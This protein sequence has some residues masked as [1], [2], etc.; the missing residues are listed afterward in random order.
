MNIG[1]VAAKDIT[2]TVVIDKVLYPARI[3]RRYYSC[4]NKQLYELNSEVI[5]LGYPYI[6]SKETV[7]SITCIYEDDPDENGDYIKHLKSIKVGETD[8]QVTYENNSNDY[9]AAL[10]SPVIT[11]DF[12]I[13]H[14][15][16]E[17]VKIMEQ[18]N[19]NHFQG[20]E[21]PI[22]CNDFDHLIPHG[23]RYWFLCSKCFRPL[24]Y[25]MT[26]Y[27][28]NDEKLDNCI[29][30][31]HSVFAFYMGE[32][33]AICGENKWV[34]IKRGYGFVDSHAREKY[35]SHLNQL[36]LMNIALDGLRSDV[37]A[38]RHSYQS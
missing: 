21:T 28:Y 36:N 23:R 38:K 32:C 33:N 15:T 11:N 26:S 6:I 16:Y 20:H 35:E 9:D 14:Y 27:V 22:V 19:L 3:N 31:Q 29:A 12:I 4:C 30:R 7:S 24:R 1:T 18:I 2:G 13:D 25:N 34:V 37:R 8:A 5:I 17:N 10:E